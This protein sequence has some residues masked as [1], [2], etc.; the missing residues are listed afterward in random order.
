M[1]V[2]TRV[3]TARCPIG[4][5]EKEYKFIEGKKVNGTQPTT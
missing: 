5:W 4:K 3:A 2:K 1:K